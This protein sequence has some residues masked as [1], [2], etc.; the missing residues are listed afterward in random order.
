LKDEIIRE[1]I[2]RICFGIENYALIITSKRIALIKTGMD[3]ASLVGFLG[4]VYFGFIGLPIGYKIGKR[5]SRDE[6]NFSGRRLDSLLG[7]DIG[8]TEISLD[9]ITEIRLKYEDEYYKIRIF[10]LVDKN[11]ETEFINGYLQ[12]P[13]SDMKANKK[14]GFKACDILKAYALE[15]QKRIEYWLGNKLTQ[16]FEV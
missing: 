14:M 11:Q 2:P 12:A 13:V 6:A 16:R 10:G 5:Y 3:Y 8:N 15:S 1:I 4:G 9:R 7:Q